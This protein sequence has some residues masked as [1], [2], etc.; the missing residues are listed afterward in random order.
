MQDELLD[1]TISADQARRTADSVV[2]QGDYL[3]AARGPS[4][5]ERLFNWIAEQIGEL[6]RAL[7]S[8]GGRGVV[9]WVIIGIFVI[10]IAYLLSRLIRNL[11]PMPQREGSVDPRVDITQ[12]LTPQQWKKRAA[13]AEAEGDWRSGI[14]CRHRAL[15]TT[16]IDQGHVASRPGL[17]A[18]EIERIISANHPHAALSMRDATWLF[19]DVWYGSAPA[20][21]TERDT[22]VGHAEQVL[23]QVAQPAIAEA[24]DPSEP[25]GAST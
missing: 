10:A 12:G 16:L 11:G 9:A 19:Q 22:F 2:S 1:P 7:T 4:L 18:G 14:R 3:R 21:A 24:G 23:E 25:V 13:E 20:T 15:V 5:R 8:F 17:T 6:F